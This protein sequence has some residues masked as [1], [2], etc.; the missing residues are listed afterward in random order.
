[1]T[2][3]E[4]EDAVERTLLKKEEYERDFINDEEDDYKKLW[5]GM[6]YYILR[7]TKSAI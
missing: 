5:D 1:M 4:R 3:R 7:T 2:K 6:F